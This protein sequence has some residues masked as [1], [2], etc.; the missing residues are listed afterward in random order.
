MLLSEISNLKF[1]IS[2]GYKT[3]GRN[4]KSVAPSKLVFA[5]ERYAETKSL[6]AADGGGTSVAAGIP[7]LGRFAS[8]TRTTFFAS[9]SIFSVQMPYQLKSISYHLRPCR[10]DTGCAW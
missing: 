2:E 8:F 6:A 5:T 7:T 1:E 10:A 4:Q 9:P 3:K